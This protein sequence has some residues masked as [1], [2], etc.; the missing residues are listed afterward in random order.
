MQLIS[1]HT[2]TTSD[3]GVNNNLFGG[4]LMSWMDLAAV[5]MAKQQV[6]SE[7][8]L[9]LKVSE[10]IFHR[11]AKIKNLLKIY[12]EVSRIGRTS[13]TI[14][15]EARRMNVCTGEED[16]ICSTSIVMVK[17]N[18]NGQPTPIVEDCCE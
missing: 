8:V 4:K 13:I 12:G 16:L 18:T 15:I 7:N 14:A 6:K 5:A 2:V 3:I 9:T 1:T 11:P 17:V 10:M